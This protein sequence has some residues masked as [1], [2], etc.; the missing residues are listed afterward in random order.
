MHDIYVN[1]VL[2]VLKS[3]QSIQLHALP[4][5]DEDPWRVDYFTNKIES[6]CRNA[7]TELHKKSLMVEEAVEEILSLVRKVQ[8]DQASTSDEDEFFFEGKY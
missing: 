5:M 3:M 1:R 8:L 7:A 6:V 2:E 4:E